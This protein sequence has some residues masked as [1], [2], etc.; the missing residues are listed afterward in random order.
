MRSPF[1]HT[2]THLVYDDTEEEPCIKN[3][4]S[5]EIK[6]RALICPKARLRSAT[7]RQDL[8]TLNRDQRNILFSGWYFTV[9]CDGLEKLPNLKKITVVGGPSGCP[10]SAWY[11]KRI[12]SGIG[13]EYSKGPAYWNDPLLSAAHRHHTTSEGVQNLVWALCCVRKRRPLDLHVGSWCEFGGH[14]VKVGLPLLSLMASDAV[15][16]IHLQVVLEDVFSNLTKSHLQIELKHQCYTSRVE[17]E[18]NYKGT[19]FASEAH[20]ITIDRL[21]SWT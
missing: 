10:G 3:C 21:S 4:K 2:I 20:D 8:C 18:N 11:F 6:Q 14:S 17:D 9:L 16:N 13:F 15:N 19:L 5:N 1:A 7:S 12:T